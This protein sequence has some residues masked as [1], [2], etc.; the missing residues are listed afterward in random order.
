M[1][2]ENTGEQVALRHSSL[3][4]KQLLY[5]KSVPR[6]SACHTQMNEC[7]HVKM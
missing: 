5:E 3:W 7:K 4:R 6:A 2:P 1:N